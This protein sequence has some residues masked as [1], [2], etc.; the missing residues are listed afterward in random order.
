MGG[1][2]MCQKCGERLKQ[3]GMQKAL[4]A[5][6]LDE[7]KEQFK[8]H[9]QGCAKSGLP[10]T[11]EHV[12]AIVGLPTGDVQMNANNS[13]GAMMNVAARNGVIQKTGRRVKA[14]RPSSHGAEL[15]EWVGL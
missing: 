15:T 5:Y 8:H 3:E 1:E 11:S 7:W 13:V 9:L 2:L 10:F 14:R 12:L 6:G 4:N